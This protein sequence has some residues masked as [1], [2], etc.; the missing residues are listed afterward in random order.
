MN[1]AAWP[2][3]REL[4]DAAHCSSLKIKQIEKKAGV[5]DG[6]IRR[7]RIAEHGASI[8]SAVCVAEVLGYDIKLVKN[9]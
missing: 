9:D 4:V 1:R 5:A 2:V 3:L 6:T 7:W 8:T